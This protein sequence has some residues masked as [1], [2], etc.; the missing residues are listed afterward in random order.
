MLSGKNNDE[1]IERRYIAASE[2]LVFNLLE[3]KTYTV[4]AIVDD[5]NNKK[6]DTG[7][8]LRKKL[9]ENVIY[10]KEE[11]KVRANYFLE[12]NTFTIKN[13]D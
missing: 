12:G 6:W 2:T 13:D 9:P 5:N 1:I 7:N 8:Y 10:Y 11:L 3:P 4:R